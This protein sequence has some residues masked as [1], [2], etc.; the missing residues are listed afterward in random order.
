MATLTPNKDAEVIIISAGVTKIYNETET[1]YTSSPTAFDAVVPIGKKW[2]VLGIFRR[3]SGGTSTRGT[4]R[5]R[6]T[7]GE[8]H[9]FY[10]VSEAQST[11]K[12]FTPGYDMPSAT[13]DA[14]TI[15]RYHC[16]WTAAPTSGILNVLVMESNA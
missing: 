16:Y 13:L 14:G 15:I 2:Q 4:L 9:V 6:T 7:D 5:Y 1:T 3:T 11:A 12:T 8:E 10:D